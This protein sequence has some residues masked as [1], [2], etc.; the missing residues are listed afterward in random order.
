MLSLMQGIYEN[1][2]KSY[3]SKVRSSYLSQQAGC[4][5]RQYWGQRNG[6]REDGVNEYL[7]SMIKN[8]ENLQKYYYR[9]FLTVK[10]S[11][12]I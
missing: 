4:T 12:L 6:Q 1:G 5:V 11:I 8:V 3:C 2:V 10:A 7:Q 9:G